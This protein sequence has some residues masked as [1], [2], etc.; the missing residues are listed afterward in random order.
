MKLERILALALLC[1]CSPWGL[2]QSN[3]SEVQGPPSAAAPAPQANVPTTGTAPQ[4]VGAAWETMAPLPEARVFHSVA[5]DAD[6]YVYVIGGASDPAGTIATSTLFRYDTGTDGWTTLAPLPATHAFGGAEV[7]GNSIY[8]TPHGGSDTTFVYDIDGNAWSSLPGSGGF[9]GSNHHATVA[10]G[11][12]LFVIGGIDTVT[13]ASTNAVWVLDT[14]L[15]TWTQ[16]VPMQNTRINPLVAALDGEIVVAGGVAFPGFAPDMT[17]EVFDGSSWQF[18]AGVP[19]GGGA[20]TRWSYAASDAGAD[21]LYVGAGRRDAGW[22]VLNHTGLYDPVT[23]AWTDSPTLPLLAQG[24]VYTAGAVAADGYFHVIGGRDPPPTVVYASN[25]R[26]FVGVRVNRFQVGGAVAGL[27]GSGL[28]LV[29]TGSGGTVPVGS[30]DPS[31]SLTLDD[32]SAYS[33]EVA[34]QPTSPSQTCVVAN[35]TGTLASADVGNIDISCTTDSFDVGGA[36]NGLSGSGL[37]LQDTVSGQMVP[38]APGDPTWALTLVDGS[39]YAFQVQ[40]QPVG[41][42]QT[43]MLTAPVSGTLAGADVAGMDLTCTTDSIA[44]GG[45][46]SGVEGSGLVLVE[47]VSGQTVAIAAGST[48]WQTTLPDGSD[49]SVALQVAPSGPSQSCTIANATGTLAGVDV[50]NVDVACG[51]DAFDVGGSISGL[52]ASGLALVES[53]SGQVLA[54]PAGAGSYAF[55]LLDGSAYD[56]QVQSQPTGQVCSIVAGSGTLQGADALDSAV[57]CVSLVLAVDT[58]NIQFGDVNTDMPAANRTIT[59]SNPGSVALT[60]SDILPPATPFSIEGGSCQPPVVLAPGESCTIIIGFATGTNGVFQD[61]LVIESDALAGP[62]VVTLS[63]AVFG[64]PLSIPAAG[65][66]GLWLLV[67]GIGAVAVRSRRG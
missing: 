30:G 44:L 26:L 40:S 52:Q 58:A 5:A 43:C 4:G 24:R 7:I 25:E 21:G 49:W 50:D 15:G 2:A 36:V 14:L 17:T 39:S 65:P 57:Q 55:Q 31:W 6:G 48:S 62:L 60:I 16:G 10:I 28:V 32:G 67:L 51:T 45:A 42:N 13:G 64:L 63:G 41:P 27:S 54:I 53:E 59:V 11:H 46:V 20:Y 3:G 47:S 23:D 37:V 18:A 9:A 22:T 1:A 56:I 38:V 19:A 12:R 34:T 29:D 8:V 33:I 61:Q 66:L 35:A